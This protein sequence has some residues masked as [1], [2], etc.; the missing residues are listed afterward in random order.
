MML[1]A[2]EFD[3]REALCFQPL[4]YDARSMMM[5]KPTPAL[6]TFTAFLLTLWDVRS[7]NS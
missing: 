7:L 5:Q 4:R 1:S 3:G 2:V 6:L